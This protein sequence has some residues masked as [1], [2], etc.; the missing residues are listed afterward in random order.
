MRVIIDNDFGG[1]PDGS[2]NLCNTCYRLRWRS[3]ALLVS[4]L[5]AGDGW[6]LQSA[7]RMRSKIEE[8]LKISEPGNVYPVYQGSNIALETTAPHKGLMLANAI[9]KEAMERWYNPL[10]VVCGAGLTDIAS[11]Y[12]LEPKIASA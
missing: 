5:R 2:S 6:D 8:V 10:Y 1:D 4:H 7:P 12:L 11:A 3:G 9:V